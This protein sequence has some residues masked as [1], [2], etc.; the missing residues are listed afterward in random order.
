MH[1]VYSKHTVTAF[2]KFDVFAKDCC[3]CPFLHIQAN[4]TYLFFFSRLHF[5]PQRVKS[6]LVIN[7]GKMNTTE[8]VHENSFNISLDLRCLCMYVCGWCKC[9]VVWGAITMYELCC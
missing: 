8:R 9:E 1:K 3:C 6:L 2:S 4:S 5:K 7:I